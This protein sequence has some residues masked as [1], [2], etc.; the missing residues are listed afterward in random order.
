MRCPQVTAAAAT[1]LEALVAAGEGAGLPSAAADAVIA[2]VRHC[3]YSNCRIGLVDEEELMARSGLVGAVLAV[4]RLHCNANSVAAFTPPL[5]H[6]A[7]A[8]NNTARAGA[9]NSEAAL[10]NYTKLVRHVLPLLSVVRRW[11]WDHVLRAVLGEDGACDLLFDL[12]AEN[13][14]HEG[15]A[16]VALSALHALAWNQH[17]KERLAQRDKDRGLA[18][19]VRALRFFPRSEKIQA[20]GIGVISIMS[21]Y[22]DANKAL[23]HDCGAI[24]V[25]VL[26]MDKNRQAAQ[27]QQQA[28]LAMW[29]LAAATHKTILD[30]SQ[31]PPRPDAGAAIRNATPAKGKAAAAAVKSPGPPLVT[32]PP[33]EVAAEKRRETLAKAGAIQALLAALQ[34]NEA[35]SLLCERAARALVVLSYGSTLRSRTVYGG[36]D[37]LAR[38]LR[39]HSKHAHVLV[40]VAA[41]FKNVSSAL[42]RD[43][44]DQKKDMTAGLLPC[45]T[46]LVESLRR[47]VSNGDFL[48]QALPAIG[49]V[50]LNIHANAKLGLSVIEVMLDGMSQ[51]WLDREVQTRGMMALY[52][53]AMKPKGA[54]ESGPAARAL[55]K[56]GI[57]TFGLRLFSHVVN[58]LELHGGDR[59]LVLLSLKVLDKF[60]E[61]AGA[62]AAAKFLAPTGLPPVT[63][64]FSQRLAG[65]KLRVAQQLGASEWGE[66]H[67]DIVAKWNDLLKKKVVKD[68]N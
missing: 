44:E 21:Y 29:S 40:Q 3:L 57:G 56:N 67:A 34:S 64:R 35:D 47:H 18:L 24:D 55:S 5:P 13:G 68:P 12:L 7:P 54:L 20:E 15:V 36:L 10:S 43:P 59:N 46:A 51:L 63:T 37:T 39:V 60:A 52:N 11:A 23:L 25:L 28:C 9:G 62:A 17:N 26:A 16:E 48:K 27:V 58:V 65:N 66:R 41:A 4:L 31:S 6:H 8:H 32:A 50:A 38:A 22:S 14:T 49:N 33:E 2:E 1:L 45:T 30:A 61:A 53:L 42:L 19:V